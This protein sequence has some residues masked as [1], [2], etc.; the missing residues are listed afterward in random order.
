MSQ[1]FTHVI[2]TEVEHDV[3]ALGGATYSLVG[4]ALSTHGR[5]YGIATSTQ[6]LWTEGGGRFYV[7]ANKKVESA[8]GVSLD[9]TTAATHEFG[10]SLLWALM[11]AYADRELGHGPRAMVLKT[12]TIHKGDSAGG[13]HVNISMPLNGRTYS[14]QLARAVRYEKAFIITFQLIGGAGLVLPRVRAQSLLGGYDWNFG[15]GARYYHVGCRSAA[16]ANN[17]SEYGNKPI[18]LD[19]PEPHADDKLFWRK[20]ICSMD[21]NILFDVIQLKLD[22]LLILAE[23]TAREAFDPIEII[24]D[25]PDQSASKR[26]SLNWRAGVKTSIGTMTA[27]QVQ[28]WY[29]R[30]MWNYVTEERGGRG[31][32]HLETWARLL[33]AF[34]T[35]EVVPWG[36]Y[37]QVDWVTKLMMLMRRDEQAE[38]LLP[39]SKI[40]QYHFAYHGFR[41]RRGDLGGPVPL[42]IPIRL[43]NEF[44]PPGLL[45]RAW[46]S[47]HEAPSGT[48]AEA[49][50]RFI[51]LR[52]PIGTINWGELK[53]ADAP[54]SVK[55]P[56]PSMATTP[57]FERYLA[58]AAQRAIDAQEDERIAREK[59][60]SDAAGAAP[61]AA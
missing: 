61:I 15:I 49:M 52:P 21:S 50:G 19:R 17:S 7:D 51:R 27:L 31:L 38:Y 40:E 13:C 57:E 6:Q 55:I 24:E 43:M 14:D 33:T 4:N 8:A 59:A 60:K 9:G 5:R 42:C 53:I 44:G 34:N 32:E 10:G 47:L 2:A 29:F 54:A 56:D 1:F 58:A 12:N 41:F 20:Q 46:R 37:G 25:S 18:L 30:K 3:L 35:D 36:L 22:L 45:A 28:W 39:Y 48:R 23:M 16:A 26:I 11:A